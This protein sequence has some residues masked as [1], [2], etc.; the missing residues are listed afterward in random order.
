MIMQRR[1]TAMGKRRP[2]RGFTLPEAVIALAI[3]LLLSAAV[4]SVYLMSLRSWREGSAQVSLQRKLAAAMQRIVQGERGQSESRQHGLREASSVTIVDAQTIEFTSGVDGVTRRIYLHGNELIYDPD[5]SS[6]VNVEKTIY[7]PARS[8]PHW[9]SSA[10]RTDL[11]F[12]QVPD[13]TIKVRL[14]GQERVRD[15]W[16]TATLLTQVMPR[17]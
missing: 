13:G 5:A 12:T 10:Y 16:M 17:N 7:D 14:V 2:S 15:R 11:E 4:V 3:F 1:H 8:E 9:D 6:S